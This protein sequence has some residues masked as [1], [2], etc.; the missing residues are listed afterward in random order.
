MALV[1]CEFGPVTL[2]FEDT[3][4]VTGGEGEQDTRSLT[5]FGEGEL[6]PPD[7][8]LAT[9]TVGTEETKPKET[10]TISEPVVLRWGREH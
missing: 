2:T 8:L 1:C 3:A 9:E 7:L 5:E 4:L 6:G 10:R